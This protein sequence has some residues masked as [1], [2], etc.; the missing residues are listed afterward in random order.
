[1]AAEGPVRASFDRLG[2]ARFALA[3]SLT[4]AT[5][6]DVHGR[7]LAALATA[8]DPE[9]EVDCAGVVATDSAGLAVLIDWK[10]WVTREG[11]ELNYRNLPSALLSLARISEVDGLLDG[12]A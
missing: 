6:A 10:G 5:A 1:M 3:G 4:F 12:R 7:G 2:P 11:R 9:I 8:V